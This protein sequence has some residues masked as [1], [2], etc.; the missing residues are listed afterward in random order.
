[1]LRVAAAVR[2]LSLSFMSLSLIAGLTAR[3]DP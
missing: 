2:V 1:V 3:P